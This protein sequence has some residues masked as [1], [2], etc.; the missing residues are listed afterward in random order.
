[1]SLASDVD[2]R[3]LA[4]DRE[5]AAAQL[6]KPAIAELGL[7]YGAYQRTTQQLGD[8]VGVDLT[9][10]LEVPIILHLAKVGLAAYLERKTAGRAGRPGDDVRAGARALGAHGV[11]GEARAGRLK[12]T[13]SRASRG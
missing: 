7:A 8:R 12:R 9:R 10:D 1:M 4:V 2:T 3:A 11:S 5:E 13:A 6:L